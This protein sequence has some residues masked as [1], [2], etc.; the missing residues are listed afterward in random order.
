MNMNGPL[1]RRQCDRELLY[2]LR[3]LTNSEG[4]VQR[5]TINNGVMTHEN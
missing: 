2:T 5:F 3:G 4:F 1:R